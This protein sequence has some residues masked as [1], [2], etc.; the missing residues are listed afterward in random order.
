MT[1]GRTSILL[2]LS[3]T[4]ACSP[5][6]GNDAA[7]AGNVADNAAAAGS[8]TLTGED[9]FR[10][11]ANCAARIQLGIQILRASAAISRELPDEAERRKAA[12][13]DETIG[14]QEILLPFFTDTARQIGP[15]IGKSMGEIEIALVDAEMAVRREGDRRDPENFVAWLSEETD[16]CRTIVANA[17]RATLEGENQ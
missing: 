15:Q 3:I 10:T 13:I 17:A 11:A 8:A 6:P 14:R 9:G 5:A 16:R 7:S 4:A 1:Q 12:E 2:L